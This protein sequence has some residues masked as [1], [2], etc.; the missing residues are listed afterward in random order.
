MK[1]DTRRGF[2][3]DLLRALGSGWSAEHVADFPPLGVPAMRLRAKGVR[4]AVD[5]VPSVVHRGVVSWDPFP[6][7]GTPHWD[8]HFDDDHLQRTCVLESAVELL[9]GWRRARLPF[10]RGAPIS[11]L[12]E[13]RPVL[14]AIAARRRAEPITIVHGPVPRKLAPTPEGLRQLRATLAG[15]APTTLAASY[16]REDDGRIPLR[17]DVLLAP[18]ASGARLSRGRGVWLCA[19]S[20]PV[21]SAGPTV[22]LGLRDVRPDNATHRWDGAPHLWRRDARA[23]ALRNRRR[24]MACIALLDA[25]AFD[26]ALAQYDI[27]ASEHVQK[28]LEGRPVTAHDS[29]LAPRWRTALRRDLWAC[30]PWLLARVQPTR[31]SRL[32]L[33]PGQRHQ[34]KVWLVWTPAGLDFERTAANERLPAVLWKRSLDFDLARLR[35][36]RS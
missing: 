36:G 17:A 19:S 4:G 5:V 20:P 6:G 34:R 22:T 26:E 8:F 27:R 12:E 18:V 24:A 29:A 15:L 14:S 16:P 25:G 31:R 21:R 13:V 11:V 35:I 7:R 28:V 1:R 10:V 32:A 9:D 23:P 3:D 33:L 30:A 2:L